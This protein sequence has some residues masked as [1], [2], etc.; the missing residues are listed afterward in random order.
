MMENNKD[1]KTG[2]RK[3]SHENVIDLIRKLRNDLI[4]DFLDERNLMAYFEE[5]FNRKELNSTKIEFIKKDLKELLI[6]PVDAKH[7]ED[8]IDQIKL[9][10]TAS[11]VE[12]NEKLF[13]QEVEKIFRKYNY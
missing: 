8:L 13:Y 6:A 9:T 11:L 10:D 4:K 5:T 2:N 7:Y 1:L 12:N 3:W